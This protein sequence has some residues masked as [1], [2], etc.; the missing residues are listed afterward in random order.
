MERE[1]EPRSVSIA[2][3]TTRWKS[4]QSITSKQPSKN[5]L[6][7]TERDQRTSLLPPSNPPPPRLPQ[8]T[9][10][11][12]L[13]SWVWPRLF[14][15]QEGLNKFNTFH[16][17]RTSI[18]ARLIFLRLDF[19]AR[20][21]DSAAESM[22]PSPLRILPDSLLG[23]PQRRRRRRTR[24]SLYDRPVPIGSIVI[25]QSETRI[26]FSADMTDFLAKSVAGILRGWI[27]LP[28]PTT[29]RLGAAMILPT[30]RQGRKRGAEA[31]SD[32]API[33]IDSESR[34]L[35]EW[36]MPFPSNS[37]RR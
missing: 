7:A 2:T 34:S 37:L 8:P 36:S 1:D 31:S 4:R 18:V 25:N 10:N 33:S 21:L 16:N 28:F 12:P 23:H 29:S 19:E 35:S 22:I 9:G 14:N 11:F 6:E 3:S 27:H 26:Q 17:S 20:F 24:P 32:I 15:W 5:V 13:P 30:H